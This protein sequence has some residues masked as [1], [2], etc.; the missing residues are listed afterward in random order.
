MSKPDRL[1]IEAKAREAV[2]R[3]FNRKLERKRVPFPNGGPSRE[4]DLFAD[5]HI[6]GG[7]S[8]STCKTSGRR[9]NT[10][11]CD[12]ASSEI[13]WLSL[14]PGPEQRMHVLTDRPMAEWLVTRFHR[15][16]FPHI[17]AIFHYDPSEDRLTKI[18][19]INA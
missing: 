3:E 16:S 6:I 10:G 7:V 5:G 11:G 1:A 8:T 12:R 13:L 4:F 14:W 15:V 9:S 2:S 19:T 18:G 17:I